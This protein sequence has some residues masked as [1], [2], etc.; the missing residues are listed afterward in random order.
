MPE[1]NGDNRYSAVIITEV[2]GGWVGLV[3][4]ADCGSVVCVEPGAEDDVF[5]K[6]DDYHDLLDD[7]TDIAAK[8]LIAKHGDKEDDDEPV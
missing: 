8:A 6:H 2:Q 5:E 7:L 3:S 1:W 4:C